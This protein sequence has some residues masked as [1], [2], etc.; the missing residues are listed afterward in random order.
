MDK[1][2]AL[3]LCIFEANIWEL[4]KNNEKGRSNAQ[5]QLS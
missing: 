2:T 4:S 3:R 1:G 5:C